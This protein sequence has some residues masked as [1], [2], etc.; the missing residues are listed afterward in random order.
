MISW[1]NANFADH[2]K[3]PSRHLSDF[4]YLGLDVMIFLTGVVMAILLGLYFIVQM[5]KRVL[6]KRPKEDAE[7][8]IRGKKKAAIKRD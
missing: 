2:L 5:L 3:L 8:K 6:C 4:Q 1:Q 7:A